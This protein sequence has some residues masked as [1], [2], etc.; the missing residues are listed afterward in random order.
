MCIM[1]IWL[2]TIII[3]VPIFLFVATEAPK[4]ISVFQGTRTISSPTTN[5]GYV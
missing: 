4:F 5:A 3:V 1:S 2:T